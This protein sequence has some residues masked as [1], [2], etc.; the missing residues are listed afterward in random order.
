MTKLYMAILPACM[1][2]DRHG[3][4][5]TPLEAVKELYKL[6]EMLPWEN[7]VADLTFE[8]AID[9]HGGYILQLVSGT[10]F[11]HGVDPIVGTIEDMKRI[12]EETKR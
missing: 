11:S 9:Y 4:G 12:A 1:G 10:S 5:E 3:I 2:E 8:M 7:G 6:W